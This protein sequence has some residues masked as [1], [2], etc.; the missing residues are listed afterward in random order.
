MNDSAKQQLRDINYSVRK[1]NIKSADLLMLITRRCLCL[2]RK[3]KAMS[4]QLLLQL[5]SSVMFRYWQYYKEIVKSSAITLQ[6]WNHVQTY[7]MQWYS[8]NMCAHTY[9]HS[10]TGISS[11]FFILSR[12][13]HFD[14][15]NHNYLQQCHKYQCNPYL[16]KYC[17]VLRSV[18]TVSWYKSTPLLSLFLLVKCWYNLAF[19]FLKG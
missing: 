16:S 2:K 5:L 18:F 11:F 3:I 8:L 19:D 17:L 14:N 13:F 6:L 7:T 9:T 1:Q 4:G 12:W 15:E 10:L